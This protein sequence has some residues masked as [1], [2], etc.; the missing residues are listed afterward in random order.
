MPYTK[1]KKQ[2]AISTKK[3]FSIIAVAVGV[4]SFL[5]LFANG[6]SYENDNIQGYYYNFNMFKMIFGSEY[7]GVNPGLL[8]AFIIMAIGI[9]LAWFMQ[10]S[11]IVGFISIAFF[12]TSAVLWL[13]TIPLY[14]NYDAGLGAAAIW[15]GILN[16]VDAILIFVGIS[17]R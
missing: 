1:R 10:K 6:L 9:I 4:L 13:C 2:D 14:G 12:V 15:L 17:Y 3:I 16:L 11:D 7:T 8:S 5:L